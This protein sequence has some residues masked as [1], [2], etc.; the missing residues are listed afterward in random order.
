MRDDEFWK[1]ELERRLSLIRWESED[2]QHAEED[3]RVQASRKP[4]LEQRHRQL[5]SREHETSMMLFGGIRPDQV[6]ARSR[7]ILSLGGQVK[8]GFAR[9]P[10]PL[11][12]RRV[13][14]GDL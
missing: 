1:W 7:R 3:R 4:A 9:P 5:G 10:R 14:G 12:G 2:Q 6:E 13:A 11:R 8:S